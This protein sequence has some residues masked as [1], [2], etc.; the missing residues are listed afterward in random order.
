MVG[1]V[2][3][4]D[5]EQ[6][7]HLQGDHLS[8]MVR[9]PTHVSPS[10]TVVWLSDRY[11][12]RIAPWV[13]YVPIQVSYADLYDAVAFFRAHDELAARIAKAGRDWS[14]RFWRR[15]DMTAYLFRYVIRRLGRIERWGIL[16]WPRLLLEYARVTS[17]DR[18]SMD[19]VG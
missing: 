4:P 15:E 18:A 6:R 11:M 17:L 9:T 5:D 3:A 7:T 19:Y 13:H 2:Q 10:L 8:G 14:Q 16:T 1:S 12:S